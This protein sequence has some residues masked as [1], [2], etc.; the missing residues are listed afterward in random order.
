VK[1][2]YLNGFIK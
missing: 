2:L 1:V